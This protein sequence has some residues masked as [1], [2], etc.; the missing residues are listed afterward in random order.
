M[1]KFFKFIG[2]L[3][4]IVIVAGIGG[5][6]YFLKTFDLNKYKSYAEDLVYKQTGRKLAI[7]GEAYLGISLIPTVI[8]NDVELANASWAQHEQMLTVKRLELKFAL[9]PLLHKEIVID[10]VMLVQPEVYLEKSSDGLVNWDFSKPETIAASDKMLEGVMVVAQNTLVASDAAPALVSTDK[11]EPAAMAISGFAAR[12]VSIQ[13]GIVEYNDQTSGKIQVLQINSFDFSADGMDAPLTASFDVVYD[14]QAI[15]GQTTFGSINQFLAGNEPFPVRADV[16]AL[17]V[18]AA[19]NGQ[20]E[21]IMDNAAYNLDVN[22]YNPAGNMNA[23]EVTFIAR[24]IGN[25]QNVKADISTL[26]VANN[27][28]TGVVSA[29]I[30]SPKPFVNVQLNSDKFDLT[31]L[32]PAQPLAWNLPE[33]NLIGSA[34]ASQLVPDT[35]VP[36]AVL[37]TVN[38]DVVINVKELII[39]SDMTANNVAVTAKLN[40]GV[41]AVKPLKLDFGGGDVEADLT[42][43]SATQKIVLK[44]SSQ[45]ILL[46]N[47]HK[48]FQVVGTTDFGIKSGGQTQIWADLTTQGATYRELVNSLNGQLVTIVDKSVLQAGSLKFMTGNI[49]T[50]VLSLI[51]LN[52][53]KNPEIDLQ[54]AVVRTDFAKGKASFPQGIA[55]QSDQLTLVS[56]GTI[57]LINDNVDFTITPS[58]SLKDANVLQALSSFIKVGGTLQNPKIELDEKQ[59]LQ[60]L[61][62]VATTGPA[63]LGSQ[64]VLDT[65]S[66]PCWKALQSTPLANRFPAPG[67]VSSVANDVVDG[68]KNTVKDTGKA[69]E[70]SVR[71]IR[72]GVKDLLKSF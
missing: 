2:I 28:V 10:N 57:N 70:K 16:S 53:N 9:L 21:H 14:N 11:T 4:L 45:N 59:A 23:P 24:I 1:K 64:L 17:G 26:N 62:G 5:G 48:G 68:T 35:L 30:S 69:L 13:N 22:V 50:Q 65:N 67:K 61:V 41:L 6:Y 58:M 72:D 60:T 54:C 12:N 18:T 32:T 40:N 27:L 33:F 63:F 39:D 15:Q 36:Y 46:Q 19:V 71:G 37:N 52:V 51:N 66:S 44:L 42:V 7:N 8:V 34:Q 43:N 38:A 55:V 20:V 31:S 49:I 3:F 25:L 47:M 29:D 56:D